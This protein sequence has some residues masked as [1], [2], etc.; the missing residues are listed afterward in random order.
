MP[1]A[2]GSVSLVLVVIGMALSGSGTVLAIE[3]PG[4]W[5]A[6]GALSQS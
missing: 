1:L 5:G 4:G 3:G 6:V 2:V